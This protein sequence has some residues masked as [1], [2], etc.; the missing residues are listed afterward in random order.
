MDTTWT[1]ETTVD[2]PCV[3]EEDSG[4]HLVAYGL[5]DDTSP[6]YV[7]LLSE[8]GSGAHAELRSLIGRRVRITIEVVEELGE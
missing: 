3:E 7:H 4:T 1:F 6:L 2:P 5:G 8:D